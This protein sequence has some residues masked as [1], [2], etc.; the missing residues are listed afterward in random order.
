M[1]ESEKVLV[2]VAHPDDEIL[3]VGGLFSHFKNSWDTR[4]VFLAEGSSARFSDRKKSEKDIDTAIRE[5]EKAAQEAAS[6]FNIGSLFFN[7]LVCG[8]LN[9]IPLID[10]NHIIK[11]HIDSFKPT[12]IFT[13][14]QFDN[15]EDH[16]IVFR[17]VMSVARPLANSSVK[18]IYSIEIPSSTNFA[19]NPNFS[20]NV[21]LELTEN[22]LNNKIMALECYKT[23]IRPYP[24][25]RSREALIATAKFRGMQIGKH[26]AEAYQIVRGE[27]K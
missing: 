16:R 18:D 22:D 17:S 8:S 10:I 6:I 15:H 21:F 19:L 23:E 27:F 26:F 4:I 11:E 1:S 25:P 12:K 14:Y 24:F 5:R 9:S 13:H 3:G 20:P 2:V 7:Q